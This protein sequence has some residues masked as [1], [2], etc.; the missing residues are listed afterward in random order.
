MSGA[1]IVVRVWCWDD[2]EGVVSGAGMMVKVWCW[3][4]G[5]GVV[6]GDDAKSWDG[7][8]SIVVWV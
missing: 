6:L 3:D 7:V 8:V 1:G 5:E 4:G 2:S